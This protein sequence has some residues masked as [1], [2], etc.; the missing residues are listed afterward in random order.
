MADYQLSNKAAQALEDIFVYTAMTYGERQ[1]EA[2]HEGF[3][4]IFGLLADFPFMGQSVDE[5]HPGMRRLRYQSHMIF[6]TK[7]GEIITI[8]HILHHRQDVRTHMS[9]E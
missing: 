5:Y 4:R 8:Q 9:D 1:S 7:D 2:Y 3:H 6:Y